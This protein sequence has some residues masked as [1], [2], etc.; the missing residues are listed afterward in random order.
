MA[1]HFEQLIRNLACEKTI[2]CV[3]DDTAMT[4]Y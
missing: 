1:G 3:F 2:N 4:A